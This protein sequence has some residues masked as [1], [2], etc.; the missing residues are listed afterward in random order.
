MTHSFGVRCQKR[1][2]QR[3]R[4]KKVGSNSFV[5]SSPTSIVHGNNIQ[6]EFLR[7]VTGATSFLEICSCRGR[8]E[9]NERVNLWHRHILHTKLVASDAFYSRE[10]KNNKILA[11]G[12]RKITIF[13]FAVSRDKKSQMKSRAI[14]IIPSHFIRPKRKKYQLLNETEIRTTMYELE[15]NDMCTHATHTHTHPQFVPS[16]ASVDSLRLCVYRGSCGI[17]TWC[18]RKNL[19]ELI[20]RI[21]LRSTAKR[22]D[23]IVSSRCAGERNR[24]EETKCLSSTF[25]H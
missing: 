6:I 16:H 15:H 4:K 17:V 13:P 8:R 25:R 9:R 12:K 10:K 1:N 23:V 20:K 3:G 19:V 11:K 24:M 18:L 7:V 22:F 14:C 2:R 5:S 21:P